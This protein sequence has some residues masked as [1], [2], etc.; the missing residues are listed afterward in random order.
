MGPGGVPVWF[1]L[2]RNRHRVLEV[3]DSWQERGRWWEQ[4]TERITYRVSTEGGGI[5]ELT[6]DPAAKR[7]QLYKAYD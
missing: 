5:F 1:R 4:E 2:G 7:W 3:L 6:W